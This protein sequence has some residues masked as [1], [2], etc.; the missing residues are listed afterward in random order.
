MAVSYERLIELIRNAIVDKYGTTHKAAK[1]VTEYWRKKDPGSGDYT[2]TL[3]RVVNW[4]PGKKPQPRR[5]KLLEIIEAM[6]IRI[7]PDGEEGKAPEQMP[8]AEKSGA[9]EDRAAPG[10]EDT[11]AE[12]VKRRLLLCVDMLQTEASYLLLQR[13][14][15]GL[16]EVESEMEMETMQKKAPE[17]GAGKAS[18]LIGNTSEAQERLLRAAEETRPYYGENAQKGKPD[19]N[20]PADS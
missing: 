11:G 17:E 16:I 18:P 2:S 3:Y 4:E 9:A 8:D 12:K 13:T 20:Q 19:G 5:S 6:G 14:A 7:P 10:R 1:A 15:E